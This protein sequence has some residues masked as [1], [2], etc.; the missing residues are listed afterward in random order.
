MQE[1]LTSKLLNLM[2]LN[3]KIGYVFYLLFIEVIIGSLLFITITILPVYLY[4]I[5]LV[6]LVVFLALNILSPRT[7]YHI[8]TI[9]VLTLL[10]L[11][12]INI[13]S[14]IVLAPVSII[15]IA[16][17]LLKIFRSEKIVIYGA[18]TAGIQTLKILRAESSSRALFFVDDD[19]RKISGRYGGI[20]VLCSKKEFLNLKMANYIDTL[21]VAIPSAEVRDIQDL[22][23]L[24]DIRI[25]TLPSFSDVKFENVKELIVRDVSF[26]NLLRKNV[27]K[28]NTER[29]TA[30]YKNRVLMVTGGGGSIGSQLVVELIRYEPRK[31]V[32]LD[33]SEVALYTILKRLEK[34]RG[35]HSVEIVD[36]LGSYSDALVLKRTNVKHEPNIVF[37]A[38]AYK[39]V[40]IVEANFESAFLNNVAGTRTMLMELAKYTNLQR[41]VLVSSDKAVNPTNLMGLTKRM[42]ELLFIGFSKTTTVATNVVRFGNVF[43]SSGSVIPLFKEQIRQGGP[44]T[45][46]DKE[47]T[48]YFMSIPEAAALVISSGA[49]NINQATF[50][51]DMGEPYNIRDLAVKLASSMGY[52]TYDEDSI[53]RNDADIEIIYTGL[54]P[55]EKLYEELFHEN[56]SLNKLEEGIFMENFSL[57]SWEDA[58][59]IVTA[60]ENDIRDNNF[61]M[62]KYLEK[63]SQEPFKYTPTK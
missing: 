12:T 40:P 38:G 63:L 27:S 57:H 36:V 17:A 60:V 44:I 39:H 55:G 33:N 53:S 20:P 54:R 19:V 34:Y 56:S 30:V 2:T 15:F 24:K 41:V 9:H 29:N 14:E 6:V 5:L 32:I 37:H 47:M 25:K 28:I 13:S 62:R 26:E 18:G 10:V 35:S 31:I 50:V 52:G 8:L 3:Y 21:V 22:F 16:L 45:V 48:R 7:K 23:A 58:L 49:T 4:N 43:N 42:C 61:E 11:N 51:L 59:S 1:I 46:T